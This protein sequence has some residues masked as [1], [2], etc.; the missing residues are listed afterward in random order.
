MQ[1][2]VHLRPASVH[3]CATSVCTRV[4]NVSAHAC[5]INVHGCAAR[6]CTHVCNVSGHT[7]AINT[8]MCNQSVHVCNVCTC[9]CDQCTW[10]CSQCVHMCAVCTCMCNVHTRATSVSHTCAV[11]ATSVCTRVC[12]ASVHACAIN[13]HTCAVSAHMCAVCAISVCTHVYNLFHTKESMLTPLPHLMYWKLFHCSTR[14][15]SSLFEMGKWQP[16]PVL[17]P[18]K[19]HGWRSLVQATVHGVAKSRTRLG[20]F[21]KLTK[22]ILLFDCPMFTEAAH[23]RGLDYRH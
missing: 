23:G 7:C 22:Y 6:V 8:H 20:D 14:R 11:C 10:M 18:R 12:N 5:A 3:M 15:A 21:T 19:S 4:C 16:T 1:S 2:Y 17:V 9:M 13:I